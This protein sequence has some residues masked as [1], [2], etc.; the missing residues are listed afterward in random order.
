MICATDIQ[1]HTHMCV[2]HTENAI[3]FSIGQIQEEH[4]IKKII[5]CMMCILFWYPR[6][7][8]N[9]RTL[10]RT[11]WFYSN[12]F[13]GLSYVPMFFYIFP[14]FRSSCI[15]TCSICLVISFVLPLIYTYSTHC[16]T[17]WK[18]VHQW[19]LWY[20]DWRIRIHRG[21]SL[22]ERVGHKRNLRQI[23]RVLGYW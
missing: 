21:I 9:S 14:M 11:W 4:D 10:L 20:H 19:R 16:T 6:F 8:F 15:H 2:L 3:V 1:T 17:K 5:F 18:T 23:Y 7:H 13:W 12:D 22:G